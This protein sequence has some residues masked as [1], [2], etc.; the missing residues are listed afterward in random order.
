VK[1][2][3]VE[4]AAEIAIAGNERRHFFA[5]DEA[6]CTVTIARREM[7]GVVCEVVGMARLRRRGEVAGYHI[8]R[9]RMVCDQAADQ[10]FRVQREIPKTSRTL[11]AE[12]GF[13]HILIDALSGDHLT[14]VATRC[15]GADPLS[16]QNGDA[17]AARTQV[18]RRR[19][20]RVAT[21]NNAD[22]EALIALQRCA[23][24]STARRR[25]VK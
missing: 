21:T 1:C 8:A 14:A 18:Q 2:V 11:L 10:G 25:L 7:L 3:A 4:V 22:V 19:Q 17:K 23:L 15:A 12:F 24:A 16:F 5:R 20:S 13:Q 6:A 9:N